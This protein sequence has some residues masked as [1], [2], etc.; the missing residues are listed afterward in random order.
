MNGVGANMLRYQVETYTWAQQK[1]Q[2]GW[3]P[4][5]LVVTTK[6]RRM[7]FLQ[8]TKQKETDKIVGGLL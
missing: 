2:E 3:T 7:K 4:L 8:K 6:L 1:F 5:L